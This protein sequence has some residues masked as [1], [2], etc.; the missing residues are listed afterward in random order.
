MPSW[1]LPASDRAS[2]N[3]RVQ[4]DPSQDFGVSAVAPQV[5]DVTIK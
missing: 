4:T 5:V 2:Y 1:T 3:L